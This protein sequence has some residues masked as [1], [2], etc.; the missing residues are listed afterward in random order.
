MHGGKFIIFTSGDN[1]FANTSQKTRKPMH[2]HMPKLR[3]FVM[4]YAPSKECKTDFDLEKHQ[5]G[6][7]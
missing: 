2:H 4:V 7:S 5:R 6:D 1:K 3:P